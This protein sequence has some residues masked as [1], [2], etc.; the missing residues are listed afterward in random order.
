MHNCQGL[1]CVC[2]GAGKYLGGYLI[3][4]ALNGI[5]MA[6]YATFI[7]RVKDIHKFGAIQGLSLIHI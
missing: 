4:G 2:D 1:E 3:E 5:F 7:E 6:S